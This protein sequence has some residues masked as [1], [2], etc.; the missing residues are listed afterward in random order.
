MPDAPRSRVSVS[1]ELARSWL[2]VNAS[3][4]EKFAPAIASEAD[5]VVLDIEDGVAPSGKD[6]A[7][8]A[9]VDWLGDADRG[10]WVRVNGFG[11]RWWEQDLR[12]LRGRPGLQGIILAMVESPE[13]I[14][15]TSHLLPGVRIMALVETARGVQNLEKIADSRTTFRLG[16]GL[17]DYR[18]DT[19]F[20]DEP[21]MLAYTRSQ[22]TIASKA[23]GLPGP[24]DGPSVGA[25]GD[26]LAAAA[27]VTSKFGMT[28]KLCLRPE[29]ARVVNEKL[30]PSP[31]DR[32]WAVDFLVEYAADGGEIRNGSDLP[33]LA[34]ANKILELSA[35]FGLEVPGAPQIVTA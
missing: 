1:P 31:E 19:G 35:A 15:R 7:R 8:A 22:F 23:A 5:I 6:S 10:A 4:S 24:V 26:E 21:L 30:S 29:Q 11:S 3:R 28:G 14:E 34:R 13:H 17:G 9:V 32:S 18:R 16:L 27:V 33:R 12:A 20:A 25:M 2:L